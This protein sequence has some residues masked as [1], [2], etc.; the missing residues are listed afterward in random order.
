M[1]RVLY[2]LHRERRIKKDISRTHTYSHRVRG[3]IFHSWPRR[4]CHPR[5]GGGVNPGACSRLGARGRC[6][7]SLARA[8]P[9]VSPRLQQ[10]PTSKRVSPR[11]LGGGSVSARSSASSYRPPG[12][13]RDCCC[14]RKPRGTFN[15]LLDDASVL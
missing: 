10:Q 14:R 12:S 5:V 1:K 13:V 4:G 2:T 11:A 9:T 15:P 7:P 3:S 6:T 8:P